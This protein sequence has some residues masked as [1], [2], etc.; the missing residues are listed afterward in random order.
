MEKLISG[1]FRIISEMTQS[2]RIVGRQIV[3]DRHG[4]RCILSV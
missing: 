2:H 4:L 3:N 1:Q